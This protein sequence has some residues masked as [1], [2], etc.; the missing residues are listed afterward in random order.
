VWAVEDTA[1]QITW[2][3]LAAGPI[4][5]TAGGV[6]AKIDHAGGPGALS[7][8]GLDPGTSYDIEIEHPDGI[9]TL[10]ATTLLPP[11]GPLLSRIATISDLHLG[12]SRW[13]FLKTM[14]ETDDFDEPH[15]GRCARAAITEAIEWGAELLVIKGDAAHHRS[16]AN[17]AMLGQ[18]VDNFPE[19]P[20]LLV[21]GNH[22]VDFARSR[23][24]MPESVGDRKLAYTTT[25]DYIDVPGLR[26]VAGD[27][28]I[29]GQGHGTLERTGDAMVDAAA[30]A[31]GPTFI[32]VHH[33]FDRF[34]RT[35][36]WPPG[37]S[38]SEAIPFFTGLNNRN[39]NTL[40][41]SGHS[42]RNRSRN[43]EGIVVTEVASTR[44]WPG[45]WA[46]YAVHEG[47]IRQVARRVAAPDA[48]IWHE[49]SRGALLGAWDFWAPGTLNQ[50]CFSMDWS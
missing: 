5:A 27:T 23:M 15:P 21:P 12:A 28:T 26:V 45:V 11:T 50:R 39:T 10:E 24:D 4:S 49:Y 40:V 8:P 36:H 9:S 44:D 30:A 35:T 47:G 13:G 29:P 32:A 18:L 1:V 48:T 6:T 25:V 46:G 20:M 33:H 7:L 17:F 41:S 19:L 31:N 3:K 43:H 37:I 2:G 38:Q 42:H 22:D 16:E 14:V 34:S